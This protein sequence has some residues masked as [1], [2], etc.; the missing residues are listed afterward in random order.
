[1]LRYEL[2]RGL[3]RRR[4]LMDIADHSQDSHCICFTTYSIFRKRRPRD[5][6]ASKSCRLCAMER[7]LRRQDRRRE[8]HAKKQAILEQGV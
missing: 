7:N 5:S 6:C 1:M 4:Q 8:R 3:M 2:E